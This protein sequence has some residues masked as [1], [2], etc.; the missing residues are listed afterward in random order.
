MASA[1]KYSG[2]ADRRI[3]QVDKCERILEGRRQEIKSE[4]N[5][6]GTREQRFLK[7][8]DPSCS[9]SNGAEQETYRK[10]LGVHHGSE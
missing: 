5:F 1:G 2:Y 3:A 7:K 8:R 10:N 6:K 9:G 4:M